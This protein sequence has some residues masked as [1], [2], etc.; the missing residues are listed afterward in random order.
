MDIVWRSFVTNV[1]NYTHNNPLNGFMSGGSMS[2]SSQSNA[3]SP[4]TSSIESTNKSNLSSSSS[5]STDVHGTKSRHSS[6]EKPVNVKAPSTISSTS[7]N[8]LNA[9]ARESN[10]SLSSQ[11][12]EGHLT[13]GT[14][15]PTPTPASLSATNSSTSLNQHSSS[16]PSNTVFPLNSSITISPSHSN[17]WSSSRKERDA[18]HLK[19]K[20][21]IDVATL[22]DLPN[23]K[24]IEDY[25]C[26]LQDKIL[27]QGRMYITA[28]HVCFYSSLFGMVTLKSFSFSNIVGMSKKN[29]AIFFPNAIEIVLRDLKFLF[30]SFIFRD[31]AFKTL[32]TLWIEHT[33]GSFDSNVELSKQKERDQTRST[34]LRDSLDKEVV[35]SDIDLEDFSSSGTVSNDE[36][37]EINEELGTNAMKEDSNNNNNNSSSSSSSDVERDDAPLGKD[38]GSH[39]SN[40][41]VLSKKNNEGA[42]I[43]SNDRCNLKGDSLKSNS[44]SSILEQKKSSE[45]DVLDSRE[46]EENTQTTDKQLPSKRLEGS[47]DNVLPQKKVILGSNRKFSDSEFTGKAVSSEAISSGKPPNNST[48]DKPVLSLDDLSI[49]MNHVRLSSNPISPISSSSSSSS[50]HQVKHQLSLISSASESNEAKVSERTPSKE[51]SQNSK[52]GSILFNLTH[53]VAS[54][55]TI[56]C[57]HFLLEDSD[58]ASHNPVV[59]INEIFPLGVTEFFEKFLGNS[60][61]FWL[62][63]HVPFKYTENTISPWIPSPSGC[64]SIRQLNFVSPV[65]VKI[66]PRKTRVVS[67]HRALYKN[68][69]HLIFEAV[70]ISKDVP[71][72][73]T[74]AL[75][76]RFNII[77]NYDVQQ[78]GHES[79]TLQ[80]SSAVKFSKSV[81]G[82]KG[83]E[84]NLRHQW[85]FKCPQNLLRV[86][87]SRI[88]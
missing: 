27:A 10:L 16:P 43:S 76:N 15:V 77:K 61:D 42:G 66:G 18:I 70:S 26:A 57:P 35:Q 84:W 52:E 24:L 12:Q 72:G 38:D 17:S 68:K 63:V 88:H 41:G 79:C 73:D 30:T 53:I 71:Y 51:K 64:C 85:I 39:I 54:S 86:L 45:S 20:K 3:L 49:A 82:M 44:N 83:S 62:T 9:S 80:V 34:F 23:E 69:E 87:C 22:F 32:H 50:L 47:A 2:N 5:S 74:F 14:V 6:E 36:E 7:S 28:D 37:E 48:I 67:T 19:E 56:P 55:E 75:V 58:V 25:S 13:S 4:S 65:S 40:I 46:E 11:I 8:L 81:W 29:T 60:S 1:G 33:S 31:Q 21:E 78:Q 59:Y